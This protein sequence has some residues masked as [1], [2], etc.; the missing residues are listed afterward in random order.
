MKQ[1]LILFI[2]LCLVS[3]S[4]TSDIELD[5]EKTEDFASFTITSFTT[6]S[7]CLSDTSSLTRAAD[8]DELANLLVVDAV[9]GE[10][11]QTVTRINMPQSQT[12]DSVKMLLSPGTHDIYLLYSTTP[13]HNFDKKALLVN[14]DESTAPLGDVQVSHQ[15]FHVE[16]ADKIVA[17]IVLERAVS[18]F[19]VNIQESVPSEVVSLRH[20]VMGGS[21][22]YNLPKMS[23]DIPTTVIKNV[24]LGSN[25]NHLKDVKT[26]IY[27]FCPSETQ[28]Y[29]YSLS[30]FDASRNLYAYYSDFDTHQVTGSDQYAA[31]KGTFFSGNASFNIVLD[32]EWGAYYEIPF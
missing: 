18:L 11:V 28:K 26:G 5:E 10:C 8:V 16:A 19:L 27:T 15:T 29:Q 30:A 4:N 13:W 31:F 25:H 3:C 20:T 23:A 12:L 24:D 6:L 14:W 17:N 22:T 2:G 9:D 32:T 7:G 21:W 1:V